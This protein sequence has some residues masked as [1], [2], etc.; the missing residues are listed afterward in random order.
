MAA[1]VM[2]VDDSK[3]IR[4][5]V[6]RTLEQTEDNY[7]LVEKG[8]GIEALQWL[9]GCQSQELPEVIVLDR[10]M[11]NMSGDECIRILKKDTQWQRIPV[12]FLTAQSDIRQ[13]VLGLAELG[14]DDY[15]PKPFDPDELAARVKVLVRIKRAEDETQRLNR[16]LSRHLFSS[17]MPM[18]S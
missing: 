9:S 18:K 1:R 3:T 15:L 10:N 2:F 11:P 8:D 12:L 14:A 13:L 17:N 7:S 16:T 5:Q 6:R 4:S